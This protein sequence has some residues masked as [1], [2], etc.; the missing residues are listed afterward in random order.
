LRHCGH[1]NE[2]V[3]HSLTPPSMDGFDIDTN[4]PTAPY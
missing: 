1:H 4:P 2:V 3:P